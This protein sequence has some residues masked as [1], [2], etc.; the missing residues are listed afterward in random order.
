MAFR[1]KASMG[2]VT[3][4]KYGIF[5]G[6]YGAANLPYSSELIVVI[7]LYRFLTRYCCLSLS[8][9]SFCRGGNL[10]FECDDAS[11]QLTCWLLVAA[12]G[13]SHSLTHF[14]C[15]YILLFTSAM[16]SLVD[17]TRYSYRTID[18][19]RSCGARSSSMLSYHFR[20]KRPPK[21][22]FHM[23]THFSSGIV[24]S[25]QLLE[26]AAVLCECRRSPKKS[27]HF[28]IVPNFILTSERFICLALFPCI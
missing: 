24:W 22:G 16:C 10:N 15:L 9:M 7:L 2:L 18:F 13:V 26:K 19:P 12:N 20:V 14:Y 8:F 17:E 4:H 5:Y 23:Y 27:R 21:T 25:I 28:R 6:L 11:S 1:M 3:Q